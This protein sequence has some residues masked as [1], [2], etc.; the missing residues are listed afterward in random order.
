MQSFVSW[1]KSLIPVNE[2]DTRYSVEVNYRTKTDEVLKA[3]AKITLGYV[4]AALKK[5]EF[6]VKQVFEEEPFR[7]MVSARNWDDGEWVVI[8]SW[9][10]QEHCYVISKGFYNKLQK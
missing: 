7:I 6:H 5:A 9:N 10:P 4:S 8:V 2:A 3:A 1:L